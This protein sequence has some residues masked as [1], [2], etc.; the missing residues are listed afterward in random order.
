MNLALWLQAAAGIHATAP[1]LA[2]AAGSGA[3]V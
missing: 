2:H 3:T 1:A